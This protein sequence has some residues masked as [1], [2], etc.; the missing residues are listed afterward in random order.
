LAK[1]SLSIAALIVLGA[2]APVTAS[3]AQTAAA[4]STARPPLPTRATV[5]KNLDTQFKGIDSNGDGTLNAAEI[6]A[7]EAKVIQ[8]RMAA[9]R[10]RV[11]GEFARLDTNK[12]GSLSKAEFMALAAQV[13][14][15][16]TNGQ[17]IL[18]QL[19]KNKD[20]K[21]SADEYRAPILAQFDAADLNHDGTLSAAEAQPKK[22]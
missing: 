16:A 1:H 5:Q 21:V 3:A 9:V 6:N 10:G 13:K 8:G 17:A 20:G 12:D 2:A 22:K 15:P 11:E 14:M 18:A 19:D 7:A 4:P